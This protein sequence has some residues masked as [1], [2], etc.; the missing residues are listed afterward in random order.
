MGLVYESLMSCYQDHHINITFSE[1]NT[2][3]LN[4]PLAFQTAGTT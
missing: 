4:P 2:H 3:Y 1:G